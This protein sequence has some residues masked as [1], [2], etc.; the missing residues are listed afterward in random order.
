MVLLMVLASMND[1]VPQRG[2]GSWF[3]Y[4]ENLASTNNKY[5]TN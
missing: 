1:D 3:G 5:L 4:C 2:N